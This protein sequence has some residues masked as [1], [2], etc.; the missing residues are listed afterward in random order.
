MN[1][2][3]QVAA[4]V[5]E[6][7]AP[8][9]AP[10]APLAPLE[11]P[12]V[13]PEAPVAEAPAPVADVTPESKPVVYEKTGDVGLD[14]ALDFIGKF[15]FGPEHPAVKAAQD[16]DF[17]LLKA[18]LGANPKALGWE[19]MVALAQR[20]QETT[21]KATQEKI[22]KDVAAIH[23]A[24]GGAEN[25]NAISAWAASNAEPAERAE[26]NAVLKGGGLAAKAMASW[27]AGRYAAAADTVKEPGSV[28]QPG[29]SRPAPAS[30]VT[31]L[32]ASGYSTEVQ[33]LSAKYH[34]NIDGRPEYTALQNRREL[35]RRQGI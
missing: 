33:A 28:T 4:P 18:Q 22:A 5:A 8:A 14:V 21:A 32:S 6:A 1:E 30:S 16:G 7:P 19:G 31:G 27:L 17:T 11:I 15:G 13:A 34:G 12:S 2:E 3:S 26:V 24:V 35:G 10:A 23:G 29:A 9:A 25:W 20:S